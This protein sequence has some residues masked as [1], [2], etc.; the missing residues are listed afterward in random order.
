MLAFVSAAFLLFVLFVQNKHD[1]YAVLFYPYFLLMAAEALISLAREGRKRGPQR[2]FIVAL[3]ALFV[4]N[5]AIHIVRPVI[6]NRGYDYYAVTERIKSAVP[7]EARI[8]GLPNWWLGL[9]DYDYRS[10]MNLTYYHFFNGYTLLQGLEAIRPQ[11]LIVDTGLQG[12]LVDEGYFPSGPGFAMYR[13][14]REEFETFLLER[15]TKVEEFVDPWHGEFQI[16][17]IRWD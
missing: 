4:L 12:L 14:P 13:L 11:Y 6:A 9:A 10:I 8:A 1:I 15:G 3:L 5:S 17:Q 2:A 7:A 16:Y